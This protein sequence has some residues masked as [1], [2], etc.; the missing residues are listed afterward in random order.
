MDFTA[1]GS[2]PNIVF[3]PSRGA[4]AAGRSGRQT[5]HQLIAGLVLVS[6]F[7]PGVAAEQTLSPKSQT[8]NVIVINFDPALKS[9]GG[10]K[11]HEYMTWSDPWK[12]TDR[13]IADARTSSHG[14]VSYRV[15]EKIEHD[16]FPTFR[17]GFSYTEES[18][19]QMWEKD[20][21]KADK[22][23]TSFRWLFQKFDL[24]AK[25][26]R[27]DAR[28]V[29][30]WGAPYFAW[31]ELH[32]KTPGD[33]IPYPTE[34]PWFYRP[35]DIPDVG[36]TVWI[37]GWNYERGEGEMLE[38]Y[39]HRIESVLSLTVGQGKWDPPKYPENAWNR[40]S[41]VD[42]D[43]PGQAEVGTVHY[44]PNSRSDY[45]WSNTNAVW[46][47]ADDWLTYPDLPRHRKLLSAETGG[48]EGIT[49]HHLWWMRHL[50]HGP[51]TTG[52][53]YNNWWQYI[54]NY[55]EALRQLPPPGADFKKAAVAMYAEE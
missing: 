20:R 49:N 25:I 33:K 41:R 42:K 16:G 40:F 46:T 35:Y 1:K 8:I 39:C 4:W 18:F 19:L 13:M 7:S 14:F 47:F 51:G 36:R 30:L 28:E 45:D 3:T 32:W 6:G 38:S 54:V 11:L 27:H 34:N 24:A 21:S 9:H 17:N 52:G 22:G 10:V 44:A 55:D 43:F 23:M 50:P 15:A 31:D 12:L 2:T 26:R 29:W 48:W 37:M 53:F 5:L